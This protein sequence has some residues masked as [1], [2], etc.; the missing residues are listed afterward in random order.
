MSKY[1]TKIFLKYFLK[2]FTALFLL[3]LPVSAYSQHNIKLEVTCEALFFVDALQTLKIARNTKLYERNVLLGPHPSQRVVRG[4]FGVV[5]A[6]HPAITYLLPSRFRKPWQIAGIIV[7]AVCI[8]NNVK[9]FK[10]YR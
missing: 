8:V 7:E 2:I 4:Y 9:N 5:M 6:A 3:M 1:F 10:K